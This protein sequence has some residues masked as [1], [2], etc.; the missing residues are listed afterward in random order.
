MPRLTGDGEMMVSAWWIVA[1]FV[2]GAYAG[3][4]LIALI[5]V[6]SRPHTPESALE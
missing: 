3:M 6:A 2:A 1:A 4:L 5:V